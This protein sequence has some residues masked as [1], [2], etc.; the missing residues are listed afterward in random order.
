MG[1]RDFSCAAGGNMSVHIHV[2]KHFSLTAGHYKCF[3]KLFAVMPKVYRFQETIDQDI[4]RMMFG[5]VH[6]LLLVTFSVLPYNIV[7]LCHKQ[8][9]T[10]NKRNRNNQHA[11]SVLH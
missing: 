2:Q 6:A 8:Y 3:P 1:R 10:E 11:Y 4:N 7:H 9:L 5:F